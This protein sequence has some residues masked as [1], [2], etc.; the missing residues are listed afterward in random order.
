[1]SWLTGNP[2]LVLAGV[3][4]AAVCTALAFAEHPLVIIALVM[5]LASGLAVTQPT[6]A[7]LLPAMVRR[8]DLAKAAGSTRRRD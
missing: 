1:V 5:V 2:P 7:A 4:Q 8:E 3:G 6:L